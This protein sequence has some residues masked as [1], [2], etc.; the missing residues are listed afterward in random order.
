MPKI[1]YHGTDSPKR[2]A[3]NRMKA[4][5]KFRQE[6]WELTFQDFKDIWTDE[7]WEQRG[8]SSNSLSLSRIYD[9]E[10]WHIDNVELLTRN[11]YIKRSRANKS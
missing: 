5:A 9:E 7:K 8:R 11:E 2:I 3:Y 10:A 6:E 4:Q 1:Q